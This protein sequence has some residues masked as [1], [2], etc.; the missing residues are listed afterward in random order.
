VTALVGTSAADVD[1]AAVVGPIV[2][3][4][5]VAGPVLTTVTPD[6]VGATVVL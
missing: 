4:W 3:L 1:W 6:V 5:T 2:V